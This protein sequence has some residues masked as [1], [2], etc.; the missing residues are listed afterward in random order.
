MKQRF[1]RYSHLWPCRAL[2][3]VLLTVAVYALSLTHG[4]AAPSAQEIDDP[5]MAD[6]EQW[7]PNAQEPPLEATADTEIAAD[8]ES[9]PASEG[10]ESAEGDQVAEGD[11]AADG[12]DVAEGAEPAELAS[13]AQTSSRGGVR[14]PA[15]PPPLGATIAATARKYLGFPYA[16]AGSSPRIGFD[17]SGFVWYV[18]QMAGIAVPNHNLA[19]QM[20]SGP[21]IP[22]D[23]LQPG[24]LLFFKN[25][26]RSGLSHGGIYLGNGQFIHSVDESKGVCISNLWDSYWAPRYLGASRPADR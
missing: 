11:Q 3:V 10:D 23:Q 19:G 8:D 21:S 6:T 7:D 26:Y 22:R 20:T 4:M 9:D 16:W 15:S 25:T 24:D 2:L 17:C 13:R 14:P 18:C 12:A 5:S 1:L